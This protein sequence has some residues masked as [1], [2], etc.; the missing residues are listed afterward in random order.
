MNTRFILQLIIFLYCCFN[1][2]TLAQNIKDSLETVWKNSALSDSIR[3]KALSEI[4]GNVYLYSNPDSSFIYADSLQQFAEKVQNKKQI[5]NA[6]NLKGISFVM[7]GNYH[8]A[9]DY[10]NKSL[11][12]SEE[13]NDKNGISNSTNSLGIIY[14]NQKDFK[15]SLEYFN[16]FYDIKQEIKDTIGMANALSNIGLAQSNLGLKEDALITHLRSIDYRKHL[17]DKLGLANSYANIGN[18]YNDDKKIELALESFLNSLELF[19]QIN[20]AYG[21]AALYFNIGKL[22][23][24]NKNLQLAHAYTDSGYATAIKSQVKQQLAFGNDLLYKIY[25]E[26]GDFEKALY[27]YENAVLIRDSLNNDE[28]KKMLLQKQFEFEYERK[29]AKI[30]EEQK[31]QRMITFF[32]AVISVFTAFILFLV[33]R[34][35]KQTKK[36]KKLIEN[37]KSVLEEKQKEILDSIKYAKRIQMALLTSEI[38]IEKSLKRLIN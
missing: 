10:I 3:L 38:Y 26:K 1:N 27:H 16:R 34:N 29:E 37:Q 2:N 12:I 31:K 23:L 24:E 21:Q 6:L 7:R 36:Q 5:A 15:K 30:L 33:Y 25:K 14:Q 9:I 22:Y 28:N 17:G 11:K 19:K 13:I 35:L 32:I 20:N 18:L 8:H 4:A